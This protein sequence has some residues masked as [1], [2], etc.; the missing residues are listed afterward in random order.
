MASTAIEAAA[1]KR[2]TCI[3]EDVPHDM[4]WVLGEERAAETLKL[5]SR[6]ILGSWLM[7]VCATPTKSTKSFR[8]RYLA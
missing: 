1:R 5:D 4:C 3:W 6:S 7:L 8:L 2:R